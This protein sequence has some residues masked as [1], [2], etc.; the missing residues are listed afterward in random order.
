MLVLFCSLVTLFHVSLAAA[1]QA[2]EIRS[3]E[4][5]ITQWSPE[6]HLYVRGDLG[7]GR[8]QLSDLEAWLDQ[9]GPHWVVVLLQNAQ[10]DVYRTPDNRVYQDMDAVEYALGHGLANRTRF[11]QLEHPITGETD[12][13]VF[14]L[15]LQERKFSYYGSDAQDR[16]DLGEA[17]WIGEL[18]APAIRAMRGGGRILD[19]V[20]DTVSN[21][22][23]RLSDT[24]AKEQAQA[25]RIQ[26][27]RERAMLEFQNDLQIAREKIGLVQAEAAEYQSK[28]AQ[29]DGELVQ[30]PLDKVRQE[31]DQLAQG[32]SPESV[33]A[34][35]NQASQL[36]SQLDGFLNSYADYRSLDDTAQAL[37]TQI[38]DLAVS[39]VARPFTQDA[40]TQLQEA[41]E[42][43]TAGNRGL[44]AKL[45]Q[46]NL[47]LSNAKSAIEQERLRLEREATRRRI[48]RGTLLTAAIVAALAALVV[49]YILN[50]RRL[51]AKKKA[52]ATFAEREAS[53]KTEMENVLQLFTRSSEILGSKERIVD[54]GYEGA[55]KELSSAAFQNVDDLLMISN[56]VQ[57]VL[58]EASQLIQPTSVT[59]KLKNLFS[60]V[61]Y[62]QGVNRLS[63]EP[64]KFDRNQGIPQVLEN[65][66]SSTGEPADF[67]T[68]TF[69]KVFGVFRDRSQTTFQ[70]LDTIENSLLNVNDRLT[71]L[72]ARI[73]QVSA[74][75]QQ[76][77]QQTLEDGFFD[78]PHLFDQLLPAVNQDYDQ[79]DK[80]AAS[81]PV[82]AVQQFLA[83]GFRKAQEA[84]DVIQVLQDARENVFPTFDQQAPELKQRG[85]QTDWIPAAIHS[86]GAQADDLFN[87]ACQRS[88][89]E[90]TASLR[91]AL[92]DLAR[93]VK[94][95]SQIAQQ[96]EQQHQ[97]LLD[98]VESAIRDARQ[99]T[100][101]RL[102][103]SPEQALVELDANPD[104][105]LQAARQ[106]F[107]SA[108]ASL[109]QGASDAAA[110]A[111]DVLL[112]E[113]GQAKSLV[114]STLKGLAEFDDL[115]R[116]RQHRLTQLQ[117]SL[118]GREAQLDEAVRHFSLAA[119]YFKASDAS[120]PNPDATL[121]SHWQQCQEVVSQ[122]QHTLEEARRVFQD[123]KVLKAIQWL[124][125]CEASMTQADQLLQEM[126]SHVAHL[127]SQSEANQAMLT[128][129]ERRLGSLQSEIQDRRTM[130]DTI[131]EFDH[132]TDVFRQAAQRM[133][134]LGS[135]RDPFLNQSQLQDVDA[136]LDQLHAAI[137]ADREAHS[138]ASRAVAGAEGQVDIGRRLTHQARTDG[139]P[140]SSATTAAVRAIESLENGAQ[141]LRRQLSDA[142][143]DWK[144][145]DEQAARLHAQLGVETGKLRGE[146]DRAQQSVSLLEQ[147]SRDVFRASGWSGRYGIRVGGSPGVAELERAR[148]AL[149]SGD[150]NI[151]VDLARAAAMAAQ[152]AIQQAEREV[153]RRR[154]EE[155]RQEEAERRRRMRK[156]GGGIS[157]GG[158]GF[159]GGFGGGGGG[160]GFGGFGG[161]GSSRGSSSGGSGSGFSRS[162]W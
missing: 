103:L 36:I 156:S 23:R 115:V 19:A 134:P 62:E 154:R 41:L 128:E 65:G 123:G 153:E 14:V 86:L 32:V 141:N 146:L 88:I 87:L 34:G 71:E 93:R 70:M 162:G 118:P 24:I 126:D 138:E 77:N 51:P 13:A 60:A 22:N 40:K 119:L 136:R 33:R 5:V 72:R 150:Y 17:Q 110:A 139:I 158:G 113:A 92:N 10:H 85:Y 117:D 74:A 18:D 159:G 35:I 64:L 106:Q 39:P 8:Q 20:K 137:Q 53:V 122:G 1:Q 68:S 95:S 67:V 47:T 125:N 102:G 155:Q 76:L 124:D 98:R 48:I 84:L 46:I 149:Q 9:H 121:Q 140:D 31:L 151:M 29:A 132:A 116:Q 2:T 145:I 54:R 82:H 52:L 157:I 91:A 94:E 16:R 38:A 81:D 28:Y 12:G 59:A 89:A 105:H 108:Q 130:Q 133:Q 120:Y 152:Y 78:V 129:L 49:L 37:Q 83:D 147:A 100:S 30:P 101:Q 42:L 99:E 55:T 7:I 109:Q 21:I 90:D 27:E 11:G 3:I 131:R 107:T 142:H 25:E 56:E 114:D 15:F 112:N 111:V 96:L 50:R 127:A 63:G 160:G 45:D 66:E 26:R 61:A 135:N 144:Q 44:A 58:G 57:R 97:P 75:D 148:R 69:E 43:R 79:A 143:G 4:D 73:D 161:G 6:Q 80:I 104:A